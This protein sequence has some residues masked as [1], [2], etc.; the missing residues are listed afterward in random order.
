MHM[1]DVVVEPLL[2]ASIDMNRKIVYRHIE[3]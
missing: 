3:V 2:Q 1:F